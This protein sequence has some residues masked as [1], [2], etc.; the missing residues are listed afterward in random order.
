MRT[1]TLTLLAALALAA[2]LSATT[3]GGPL[4]AA[5]ACSVAA[6]RLIHRRIRLSCSLHILRV[7]WPVCASFSG[8]QQ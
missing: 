6:F 3:S 7:Q 4:A 5:P 8:Q 1:R 2:G